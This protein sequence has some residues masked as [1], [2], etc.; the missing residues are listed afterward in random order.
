MNN[1]YV[2]VSTTDIKLQGSIK[3]NADKCETNVFFTNFFNK[4]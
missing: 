3:K 1:Y 2:P 4:N